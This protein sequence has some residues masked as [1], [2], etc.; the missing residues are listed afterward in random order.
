MMRSLAREKI[1]RKL[2]SRK[3]ALLLLLHPPRLHPECDYIAKPH[4][5][6]AHF[7][8]N[9]T[10]ILET[11]IP[12]ECLPHPDDKHTQKKQRRG[13]KAI[14]LGWQ[15]ERKNECHVGVI[16]PEFTRYSRAQPGARNNT[17]SL[18]HLCGRLSTRAHREKGRLSH[19]DG[20]PV[21]ECRMAK[22]THKHADET[23]TSAT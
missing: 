23:M 3:V 22:A 8:I 18:V 9:L 12:G 5:S 11:H 15:R 2:F 21:K 4:L 1:L 14:C 16:I 17:P 13:S 6:L 19:T 20:N 10:Q 7:R